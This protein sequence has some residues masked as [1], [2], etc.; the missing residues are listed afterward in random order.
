M[1][2]LRTLRRSVAKAQGLPLRRGPAKASDGS[3]K[4]PARS[5]SREEIRQA[6]RRAMKAEKAASEA[7]AA[8]AM[9]EK[10]A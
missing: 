8:V 2:G 10:A 7:A 9:P 4:G 1:S 5:P 6:K 3:A